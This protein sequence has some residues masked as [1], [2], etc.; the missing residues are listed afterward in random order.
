MA[1]EKKPQKELTR[2]GRRGGGLRPFEEMERMFDEFFPVPWPRRFRGGWGWP[3]WPELDEPFQG[4]PPSVDVIEHDDEIVVHAELPGVDRDDLEVT[5]T[6]DVLT[7]W[8]ARQ[9]RRRKRRANT[10]GG[11][12]CVAPFHERSGFRRTWTESTPSRNSR[13]AYWR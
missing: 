4:K 12:S 13:T 10:I 3:G 11:R 6:D 9:K 2:L 5:L 7:I 1:K 8:P